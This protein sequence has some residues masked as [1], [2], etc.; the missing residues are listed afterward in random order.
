[1]G[2]VF[3][4]MG[5][6][7]GF[8]IGFIFGAVRER[9]LVSQKQAIDFALWIQLNCRPGDCTTGDKSTVFFYYDYEWFTLE[10]LF[11]VYYNSTK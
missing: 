5:V 6:L 10:E 1:M 2:I 3:S 7:I 8:F 11:D 4:I 9:V